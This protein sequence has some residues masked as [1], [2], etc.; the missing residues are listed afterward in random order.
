MRSFFPWLIITKDKAPIIP[1]EKIAKHAKQSFHP[2]LGWLHRPNA[3]WHNTTSDGAV[4]YRIDSRGRRNNPGFENAPMPVAVYG[5][6]YAFCRLVPDDCTWPHFMS[7]YLHCHVGNYGV[8]NYGFDQAL[9]RYENDPPTEARIVIMA[10]VPETIVRIQSYWKHYFEYGNL[11]A[12]KPRF[13]INDNEL[14]FHSS[15]ISD[16]QDYVTYRQHI[17]HIQNLDGF[18]CKKFTKDIIGFPSML[19]LLR[20]PGRHMGIIR[21][22]IFWLAIGKP[23]IAKRNALKVI[24]RENAKWVQRL[25]NDNDSCLLLESLIQRFANSCKKNKAI[26]A[27]IV[28]PQPG[29]V[30]RQGPE[31][32]EHF[33][34]N[35]KKHLHVFDFTNIFKQNKKKV[36]LYVE[37]PI[38]PHTSREANDLIAK[39][40]TEFSCIMKNPV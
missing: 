1:E 36:S 17:K 12:F 35:M 8:G 34:L 18:Y 3:Q 37:G 2:V 28:L 11:L 16:P 10:V 31:N 30:N 14:T 33:F 29:D 24:L 4:T 13:T 20:K 22:L 9:I 5:D 40:L 26:P 6:S 19:C 38:G 15:I 7:K 21:S 39:R 25:Y 32:H 27:L 23:D